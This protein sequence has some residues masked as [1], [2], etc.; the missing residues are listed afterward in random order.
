M[1]NKGF[2]AMRINEASKECTA[3]P[4]IGSQTAPASAR[5]ETYSM[6]SKGFAVHAY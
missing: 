2:A 5:G 6:L 3:P 4:P 1:L